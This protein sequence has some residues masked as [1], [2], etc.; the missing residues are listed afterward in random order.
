M[1]S[2]YFF[3]NLGGVESHIY[4]LAHKMIQRGHRVRHSLALH[5]MT[6]ANRKRRGKE[7]KKESQ[8]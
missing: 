6:L 7:R 8:D 3:P 5:H 2:D 1:V 4:I